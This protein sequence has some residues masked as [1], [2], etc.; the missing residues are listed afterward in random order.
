MKSVF[1]RFVAGVS[2]LMSKQ[3]YLATRSS[4]PQDLTVHRKTGAIY[5][6]VASNN[7]PPHNQRQRRKNARRAH[8]AG[9]KGVFA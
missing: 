1:L 6:L 4:L 5:K 8:A 9:K 2:A 7:Q 3:D